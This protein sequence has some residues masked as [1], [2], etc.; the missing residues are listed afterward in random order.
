MHRFDFRR[1]NGV[2]VEGLEQQGLDLSAWAARLGV[3]DGQRY[4]LGPNGF[5]DVRVN[6]FLASARMRNLAETTQRDYAHALALWLN[7]LET[8]GI[9]WWDAAVDD[10]EE[11][12]FWRLIDPANAAP[13]GTSTFAKD[14]AACKKFYRWTAA[15]FPDV[16]DVFAEVS[17]PRAK[18][19]AGV[20]WL[21]PAAIVRW[22]DV[23]LRGRDLS[24]RRDRSW[25]GRNEQ[26]DSAFVDGLYGTGLRL[27][28]WASVVL[29]ELPT[30][31]ADRGFFTCQLADACAKGGYGHTYWMPR[32]AL[33]EVRAYIE[34]ARARAVRDAQ[35]AGRYQ[36]MAGICVVA[37][38]GRRR[39]VSLPDGDA[40]V[41][42]NWNLIGPRVRRTLFR[43]TPSGLEPLALWLNE[44][45]TPRDPHGW[46]HTFETG[47]QRIADLGLA[48][49]S[50]TP[51]MCRHSFALK[52]FSI[53]RLVQLAQLGHLSTQEASDFRAQFGDTWHLV[54]TM[55][56]H[57]RV[58]TTKNVYLEPFR[59][60]DVEVLLTHADGFPIAEFM[61]AAFATHPKVAGDPL[62]AVQ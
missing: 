50:C 14:V 25:K 12:E 9:S 10:A 17:F 36:Q 35:C 47:N 30:L 53:A 56:G 23:G 6:A 16:V 21:D 48:D 32:A 28:E 61:A 18:R 51:H 52:W 43:R 8:R 7:F 3:R 24:G 27:T 40:M 31:E 13:V 19:Q 57:A 1:S 29:P 2:V 45:G 26:R 59:N 60:L 4:L 58:E 42:R 39:S 34:G 22:R 49:F 54:Q 15:R 46:H 37:E 41:E 55:L 38:T 44:D 5:P 62:M 33:S 20:K 11:F